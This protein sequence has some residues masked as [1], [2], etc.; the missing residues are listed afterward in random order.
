LPPTLKV[1]K[2][3]PANIGRIPRRISAGEALHKMRGAGYEVIRSGTHR[4]MSNGVDTIILPNSGNLSPWLTQLVYKAT[5]QAEDRSTTL[6]EEQVPLTVEY[7]GRVYA[8]A[9]QSLV[10]YSLLDLET[11]R[12]LTALISECRAV[13]PSIQLPAIEPPKEVKVEATVK[14]EQVAQTL[15]AMSNG[16]VADSSD[17]DTW[18]RMTQKFIRNLDIQVEQAEAK[19]QNLRTQRDTL[20]SMLDVI[21]GRTTT[22]TQVVPRGKNPKGG[23][24]P[25]VSESDKETIRRLTLQ[26]KSG[27]EIAATVGISPSAVNYHQQKL[28]HAGRLS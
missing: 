23:G 18:I 4:I 1:R 28:R 21:T 13:K 10:T 5:A 14:E 8:V 20:Q 6:K 19:A 22:P 16:L 7:R 24:S 17:R 11:G 27:S 12:K 26:R 9:S 25:R 2:D 3:R 15:P